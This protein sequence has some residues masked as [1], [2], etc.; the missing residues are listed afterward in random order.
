VEESCA[1]IQ[2]QTPLYVGAQVVFNKKGDVD[3]CWK[4]PGSIAQVA[5]QLPRAA[6][7]SHFTLGRASSVVLS[8]PVNITVWG[9]VEDSH[10]RHLLD[11]NPSLINDLMAELNNDF[12]APS[13]P[14]IMFL[15]L[16][17]IF[18]DPNSTDGIQEFT[19]FPELDSAGIEFGTIIFQFYSDW[20]SSSTTVCCLDVHGI[21][22]L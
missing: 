15:P 22:E 6:V 18:Y 12:P 20:G 5:I 2:V 14:E 21:I 4:F 11:I 9:L 8:S 10:G 19:I 1:I 13:L 16:T 3:E 7:L 17:S